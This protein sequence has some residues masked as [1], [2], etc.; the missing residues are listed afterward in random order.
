MEKT[1]NNIV[2]FKY[3]DNNNDIYYNKNDDNSNKYYSTLS[4]TVSNEDFNCL[5]KEDD[6][7]KN[8]INI[9]GIITNP[10]K[11]TKMAIM[12]PNPID[13]ITSFSGKGLPFPCEMIAFEN[14]PNFKIINKDGNIDV[15]MK[16]PNSYYTPDGYNKIVSPVIISLDDKKIII[17]LK[18]KCPLKTI[19]DRQRGNPSFYGKREFVLPI[20]TAEEV[21]NNYAYAKYKLNIA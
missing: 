1:N 19:R 11:Y 14:T 6:L 9:K 7:D 2:H 20:G 5:I 12:A 13:K 21:M 15:T 8:Y 16:Y 10:N 4:Y 3:N 17:E 18:D